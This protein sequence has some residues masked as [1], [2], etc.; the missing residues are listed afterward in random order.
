MKKVSIFVLLVVFLFAFAGCGSYSAIFDNFE[1]EEYVEIKDGSAKFADYAPEF[2]EAGVKMHLL[3]SNKTYTVIIIVEF[4]SKD[5]LAESLFGN[6]ALAK[7]VSGATG[8]DAMAFYESAVATG[9]VRD[10]CLLIP[11]LDK[12]AKEIFNR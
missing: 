2:V 7:Y 11:C 3:A 12:N 9:L 4:S 6:E 5:K 8:A 1:K 10:N